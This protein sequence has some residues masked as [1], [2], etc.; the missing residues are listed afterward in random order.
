MVNIYEYPLD[1]FIRQDIHKM[2]I[3]K[4]IETVTGSDANSFGVTIFIVDKL[5][6]YDCHLFC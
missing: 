4:F 1:G 6:L 3:P 5:F 2:G